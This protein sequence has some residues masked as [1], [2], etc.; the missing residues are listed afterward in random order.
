MFVNPEDRGKGIAS[1]ILKS[2]NLGQESKLQ[3]LHFGNQKIPGSH[4]TVQEKWFP[5]TSN[6]GQYE[7]IER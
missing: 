5:I 7:G 2:Q 6:Y 3:K 1:T 4:C